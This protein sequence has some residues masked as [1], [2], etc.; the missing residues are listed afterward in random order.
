MA[1]VPPPAAA[2]MVGVPPQLLTTLGTAAITTPAVSTSLKLRPVRAGESAGLVTVKVRVEVCPTPM[3]DGAN[4]LS[5]DGSDCTVSELAAT[6]L[7]MRTGQ[8]VLALVLVY[9]PP[10][11]LP[12]TSTLAW[13]E[14]PA[15]FVAAP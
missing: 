12:M 5:S 7:V 14:P 11:A 10:G 4:A 8:A 6:L 15:A 2:V 1:K 3:V 9:E 13:H